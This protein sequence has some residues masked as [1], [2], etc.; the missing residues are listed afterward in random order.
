MTVTIALSPHDPE[1]PSM[2]AAEKMR[3]EQALGALARRVEHHG[4]TSIPGLAAKPIIDIQV[5]V[6][7]L[8]RLD[9]FIAALSPLGYVHAPHP[10]DARCPFF[11][12]PA[13][14]PHTYHVHLVE[15]G[16]EEEA[17]TLAFRDYL[18]QHPDVASEYEHL[19]HRLARESD[20]STAAGREAYA[21]AKTSF[22]ERVTQ[23]ALQRQVDG[24]ESRIT[25]HES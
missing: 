10:D 22:I 9:A 5:S 15:A 16:G 3:L 12:R 8:Q 11:H 21:L 25:N 2:F 23:L 17:R 18:K 1:W 7:S 19:K 6:E 13:D 14:W 24:S 20:G 4:S